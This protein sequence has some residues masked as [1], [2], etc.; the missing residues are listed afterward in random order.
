[1]TYKAQLLSQLSGSKGPNEFQEK[2]QEF[3]SQ[4]QPKQSEPSEPEVQVDDS[5]VN[6]NED[7]CYGINFDLQSQAA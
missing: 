2:Y 4:A 1:M 5:D 7:D 3:W 6:L